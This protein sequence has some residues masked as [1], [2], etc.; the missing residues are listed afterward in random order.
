MKTIQTGFFTHEIQLRLIDELG[1][2]LTS[3]S[4]AIDFESFRSVLHILLG[5]PTGGVG[6]PPWDSI[7]MFKI[8]VLQVIRG[9]SDEKLEFELIDSASAQR[10]VG[11]SP[12]D[13]VPDSR[14]IWLYQGHPIQVQTRGPGEYGRHPLGRRWCQSAVRPVLRNA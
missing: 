9:L 4:K 8:L 5:A 3:I 2:T 1:D 6:R 7:L 10:V 14:T 12:H 13:K 11:I